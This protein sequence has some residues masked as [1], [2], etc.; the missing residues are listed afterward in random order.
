MTKANVTQTQ[1]RLAEAIK[2]LRQGCSG[3]GHYHLIS[4]SVL[5]SELG[6]SLPNEKLVLLTK[7]FEV[8]HD[9]IARQDL[10]FVADILEYELPNIID[11]KALGNN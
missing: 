9:A 7:M 5:L 11:F 6:K 8:C 1:E 10:L 4:S 3:F 2:H